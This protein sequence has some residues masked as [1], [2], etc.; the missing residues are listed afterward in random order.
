MTGASV[1]IDV[2][3]GVVPFSTGIQ[4]VIREM[5]LNW[6]G[7]IA[8]SEADLPGRTRPQLVVWDSTLGR[9]RYARTQDLC[10]LGFEPRQDDIFVDQ[11]PSWSQGAWFVIPDFVHEPARRL[12]I[13][14]AKAR[15][16]LK[17]AYLVHDCVP[18]SAPET[19]IPEMTPAF[20]E[21][22]QDVAS[23]ELAFT[24]SESTADELRACLRVMSQGG[25]P[26][27]EIVSSP[28]ASEGLAPNSSLVSASPQTENSSLNILC[29]GS[30]EPR[31]NHA[32][33]LY[34]CEVLWQEG[35][36]FQLHLVATRSWSNFD[37]TDFF[38]R[39]KRKG[40]PINW[41]EDMT[42]DQLQL[43][44]SNS[45]VFVFPSIHEGFGLPVIEALSA[46]L[47]V[48]T[49]E[50][51]ATGISGQGGGCILIDPN[52]DEELVDALRTLITNKE[53]REVLTK[54]ALQR[55]PRSWRDFATT[56][57]GRLV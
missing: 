1:L 7:T 16:K 30:S 37:E 14:R 17:V 32:G 9:Y 38:R 11:E 44:Y 47:P 45:D 53:L 49:G 2:S 52:N 20:S 26:E 29:V 51:G 56:I 19:S 57:A 46:G 41:Y 39:L 23:A 48:I 4:R 55:T 3:A 43:L 8:S 33:L 36:S 42:D 40:R 31:K 35:L 12:A 28:L 34:A 6:P 18:V 10:R 24:V 27:T 21:Y 13:H 25:H 50:F 15:N 22:L 5:V 54:S